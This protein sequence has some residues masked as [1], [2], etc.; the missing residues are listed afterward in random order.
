M[1]SKYE[2]DFLYKQQLWNP[3]KDLVQQVEHGKN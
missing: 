3:S 1:K 2:D